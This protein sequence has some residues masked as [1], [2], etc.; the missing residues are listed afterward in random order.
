MEHKKLGE[1]NRAFTTSARKYAG[2]VVNP[3]VVVNQHYQGKLEHIENLKGVITRC[4]ELEAQTLAALKEAEM[5][6][7]ADLAVAEN[8]G[9]KICSRKRSG[10]APAAPPQAPPAGLVALPAETPVEL[11]GALKIPARVVADF[12]AVGRD[13]ALYWVKSARRFAVYIAGKLF[14]G[15]IGTIYTDEKHPAKIKACR[16]ERCG[17]DCGYYHDPIS[18]PGRCDTR[19][20]IAASWL[21]SKQSKNSRRFGSAK[22]LELD[23]SVITEEEVDRYLDQCT[24]DILCALLLRSHFRR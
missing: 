9:W 3:G 21:Y 7:A 23:L 4:R 24:H 19:N 15:N 12:A 5:A 2:S 20:F 13:G 6:H 17:P 1:I 16:A 8:M 22:N 10:Q 18:H 14:H 11:E